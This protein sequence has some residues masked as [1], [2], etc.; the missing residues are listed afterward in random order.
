MVWMGG[1]D[2]GQMGAHLAQVCVEPFER[3]RRLARL[4]RIDDT[5]MLGMRRALVEGQ[6]QEP[7]AIHVA[8]LFLYQI[9]DPG[10]AR[11]GAKV[12]MK[13]LV[14]RMEC[15]CV[16]SRHDFGLS[17]QKVAQAGDVSLCHSSTA[18]RRQAVSSARRMKAARSTSASE[19]LVTS[20]ARC[21][22]INKNP[23]EASL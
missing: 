22:R 1:A 5:D 21:G 12:G 20:V 8:L 9:P 15:G 14:Q 19:I 10:L 7:R 3:K 23:R 4:Q 16:P 6:G 17:G 13:R 11:D 2:L 18:A